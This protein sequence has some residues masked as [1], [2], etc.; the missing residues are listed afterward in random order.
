MRDCVKSRHFPYAQTPAHSPAQPVSPCD[1]AH[2]PPLAKSQAPLSITSSVASL[3]LSLYSPLSSHLSCS[4]AL[5][6]ST[7]GLQWGFKHLNCMFSRCVG[8]C[9][10][11]HGHLKTGILAVLALPSCSVGGWLGSSS[12]SFLLRFTPRKGAPSYPTGFYLIGFSLQ[13]LVG[14]TEGYRDY[15]SGMSNG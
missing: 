4:S 14:G 9:C 11:G 10:V 12:N 13:R 8:S 15:V 7:S 5:Q 1:W 2:L 6:L 3:D